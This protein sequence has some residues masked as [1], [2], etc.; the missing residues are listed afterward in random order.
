MLGARC[1]SS[2]VR[3][4]SPCSRGPATPLSSSSNAW[5]NGRYGARGGGAEAACGTLATR[6]RRVERRRRRRRAATPRQHGLAGSSWHLI[7]AAP[8]SFAC[9]RTTENRRRNPRTSPR[10]CAGRLAPPAHS[11]PRARAAATRAASAEARR[12]AEG[13]ARAQTTEKLTDAP[14]S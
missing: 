2:A 3:I 14:G 7:S 5:T 6:R 11:V 4:Y 13:V 10:S 12:I 9:S 1:L 8:T